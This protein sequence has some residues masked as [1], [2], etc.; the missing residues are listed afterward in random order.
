MR[1]DCCADERMQHD[2]NVPPLIYEGHKDGVT[3]VRVDAA[4][5]RLFTASEDTT[6]RVWSLDQGFSQGQR[7]G[8]SET[9]ETTTS[10]KAE[11]EKEG[12]GKTVVKECEHVL[13]LPTDKI[14]GMALAGQRVITGGID[15]SPLSLCFC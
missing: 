8:D 10:T 14:Y 15:T 1:W 11:G 7:C 3:V 9:P 12:G 13:S 2:H 6:L 4:N 5:R